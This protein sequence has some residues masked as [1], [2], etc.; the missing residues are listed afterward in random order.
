M[1]A[2]PTTPLPPR[3]GEM[4]VHVEQALAAAVEAVARREQ[5]LQEQSADPGPAPAAGLDEGLARFR[6]RLRGLGD[7][8]ARAEQTVAAADADL[9]TGE[10]ALRQWLQAAEAARRK[11]ADW[12]SK[13]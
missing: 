12:A 3:W 5:A 9:A 11:L 8:A 7:C 2:G 1:T 10:E 4:L 13:P 6:E